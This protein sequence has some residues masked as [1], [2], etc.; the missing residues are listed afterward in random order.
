MWASLIPFGVTAVNMLLALLI[1]KVSL[2]VADT[3]TISELN[4]VFITQSICGTFLGL[5]F[6]SYFLNKTKIEKAKPI[7]EFI[8]Y[9]AFIS[10]FLCPLFY[11]LSP[12]HYSMVIYS[13]CSVLILAMANLH[14]VRLQYYR[15]VLLS[16]IPNTVVMFCILNY[17][18]ISAS[19][20]AARVAIPAA[21]ILTL[22]LYFA[23]NLEEIKY[24][25]FVGLLKFGLQIAPTSLATLY[26]FNIVRFSEKFDETYSSHIILLVVS[27]VN[28]GN[29]IVDTIQKVL[30]LERRK[31]TP[32]S[33]ILLISIC[34][35]VSS[36]VILYLIGAEII[37]YIV[38]LLTPN[39]TYSGAG[40]II[41][42]L[43]FSYV[44]RFLII[45]F[46]VESHLKLDTKSLFIV[47]GIS[48]AASVGYLLVYRDPPNAYILYFLISIVVFV[49]L[50]C[51]ST[52][53]QL[54]PILSKIRTK[55]GKP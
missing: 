5:S 51:S 13:L 49:C 44:C 39:P 50:Y 9:L 20:L 6:N 21:L 3:Q 36:C 28:F 24:C 45:P 41:L 43:T 22:S 42:L 11:V 53:S 18:Y 46:N 38:S 48:V 4:Y 15:Y 33:I 1:L 40:E 35:S 7:S 19:F 31:G 47:N 37:N 23:R 26:V 30:M 25:K 14:Y 52:L 34:L 12:F 17:Q 54:S 10:L 16:I 2:S 29:V 32:F 27:V 55:G 8:T